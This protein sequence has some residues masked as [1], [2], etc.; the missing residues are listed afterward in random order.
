MK[1]ADETYMTVDM[2]IERA[3]TLPSEKLKQVI[4]M[5]DEADDHI[6]AARALMQEAR[7]ISG[8]NSAKG[9]G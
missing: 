8:G 1:L 3:K 6:E 7:I 9:T 4:E 5:L 2:I